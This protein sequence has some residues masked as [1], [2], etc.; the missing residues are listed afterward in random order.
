M[1]VISASGRFHKA[2][3]HKFRLYCIVLYCFYTSQVHEVEV[4]YLVLWK[5]KLLLTFCR[6]QQLECTDENFPIGLAGHTAVLRA[7]RPTDPIKYARHITL[8]L[9]VGGVKCAERKIRF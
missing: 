2:A 3:L 1:T 9:P 7:H 6:C 4:T 5:L 8:D